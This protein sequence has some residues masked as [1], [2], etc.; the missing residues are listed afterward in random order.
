MNNHRVMTA[1]L[2]TA[3]SR[4]VTLIPIPFMYCMLAIIYI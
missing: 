4:S 1:L 2:D 3:G